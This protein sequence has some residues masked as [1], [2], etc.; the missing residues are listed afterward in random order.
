[1]QEKLGVG[2]KQMNLLN[3]SKK[4][5]E[6]KFAFTPPSQKEEDAFHA[7][8]HKEMEE[9]KKAKSAESP[10]NGDANPLFQAPDVDMGDNPFAVMDAMMNDD[11]IQDM[12]NDLTGGSI[13]VRPMMGMDIESV[14]IED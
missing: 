9:A 8:L 13:K 3:N 10:S 11:P 5:E 2:N 12:I 4:A 1:M 6:E 7:K 14:E